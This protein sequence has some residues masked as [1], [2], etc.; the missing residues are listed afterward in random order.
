M[1]KLTLNDGQD[2]LV[3]RDGGGETIEVFD[4]AVNTERRVGTGT[5]LMEKLEKKLK[6]GTHIHIFARHENTRAR[7]FYKKHGYHPITIVGFYPDG[8]ANLY[9][10]VV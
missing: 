8:D 5:K 4:I 7:Q 1:K 3:Y 6:K 2:F 10:K 9:L